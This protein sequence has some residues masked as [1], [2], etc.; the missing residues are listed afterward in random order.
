MER[1]SIEKSK[2]SMGFP[3]MR[4]TESVQGARSPETTKTKQNKETDALVGQ[5]A[6]FGDVV[7]FF[8]GAC[9]GER[10]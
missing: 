7:V 4:G 6:A 2:I 5:A 10:S 8:P 3:L 1:V 9:R